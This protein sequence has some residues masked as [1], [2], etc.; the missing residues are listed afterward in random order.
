MED[1]SPLQKI[2]EAERAALANSRSKAPAS[3]YR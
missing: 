3:R 1:A 2:G